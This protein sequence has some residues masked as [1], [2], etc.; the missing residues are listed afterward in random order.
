MHALLLSLPGTPVLYYGDEIGMGDNIWLGDRNGVRTPMQWSAD[1][2]AGFS[3]ASSQRLYL[4]VITEP[5]YHYEAVNVEARQNNPHSQLWWMK[6]LIALR[7]RFRAFGRGATEF[8]YSENRRVLAFVRRHEEEKLLVVANL[9]RFSQYAS[10]DLSRFEG[11]KAVELFGRTEFPPIGREPWVL[12]LGPHAFFWFEL[13]A[14]ARPAPARE[15]RPAAAPV[16]AGGWHTLARERGRPLENLLPG[17]LATR[18]WFAGK[19]REIKSA[20]VVEAVSF[21]REEAPALLL[22]VD[23]EYAEGDPETYSLPVAS[24]HGP[25]MAA[26]ERDVPEAILA[27]IPEF[28]PQEPGLLVE[29]VADPEC[30]AAL[31]DLIHRRRKIRGSAGEVAGVATRALK[32]P[33]EGDPPVAP[34]RLLRAEQS[35]TSLIFGE[36]WILKLYRRLEEGTNP[37]W[38][39]GGFLTERTEL[40]NVPR[41]AGTIEYR[42]ARGAPTTLAL[43]QRLVRNEGNAWSYTTDALRRFYE[44]ALMHG[45]PPPPDRWSA[46]PPAENVAELPP[47]L[48]DVFGNYPETARRLG[49]HTAELHL[50]LASDPERPDFAPEP[51]STLYQRSIYQSMRNSANQVLELVKRRLSQLSPS[52]RDLARRLL[53]NEEALHR[54]LRRITE[55]RLDGQ[56]IRIH[57]DLHLGQVLYTG[58]D[59]VLI[60]FEGEPAR[61]LSW[62]KLKRSPL[63]DVAGMLRSFHYAAYSELFGQDSGSVVRPEDRP[64]LEPWARFWVAR[65][66]TEF[67]GAY[68]EAAGGSEILPSDGTAFASLLEALMLEKAVYEVGYELASRPEWVLVPLLGVLDLL[69]APA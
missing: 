23:V 11:H 5:E 18:R 45:G 32:R 49:R 64:V 30:A 57:G 29:A 38:E 31:F 42:R 61:P 52:A 28:P 3:R 9:S 24:V 56:R 14:A 27:R 36:S 22:I 68:R 58:K 66:C 37:E 50:A 19:A 43:L 26:V 2:N 13:S 41:V 65:I 7:K 60:D 40:A 67:L 17:I 59:F 51:L 62:R 25:R 35:N 4:P 12:T 54:K 8:L 55:R 21:G 46:I 34:S 33:G 1:R 63:R 15:A 16:L 39:I 44:R 47:D 6:R 20:R 69:E 53:E 48:R 10:V